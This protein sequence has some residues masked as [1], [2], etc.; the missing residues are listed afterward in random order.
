MELLPALQIGWLNGWVPLVV[1]YSTFGL[2]L[3]VF[4]KE[5]VGRLYDRSG[6]SRRQRVLI[7]IGKLIALVWFPLV[8]FTPLK[9]G[10]PVFVLGIVIFALGLAGFVVA[11]FNFRNTPLDQPVTKGLYRVSRHPQQFT[12][13]VSAAGIAIA[14]GSWLA[15]LMLLLGLV[16]THLKILAEEASCLRQYGDSYRAYMERVPRYFLFF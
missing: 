5:V 1:L 8:I 13:L 2:L 3:L 11:L 9:I 16:F 4:S 14:I 15:L 12:L 7:L 10:S 6:W